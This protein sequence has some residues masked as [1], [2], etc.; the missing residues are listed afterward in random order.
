[1]KVMRYNGSYRYK[2][3]VRKRRMIIT[4]VLVTAAALIVAGG[5]L[6]HGIYAAQPVDD[7]IECILRNNESTEM[8]LAAG[9]SCLLTLPS[10]VDIHD[11]TFTSSDAETVRVDAA[12]R[13]DALREGGATVTA[14]AEG[15]SAEC[16]FAVEKAAK[17]E[18]SDEITTAYTA[19]GDIVAKNTKNGTDDLYN[20]VVNRRSNTVTVYTYDEN[21]EYT[22]PVRAMIASCGIGGKDITLT[23][24]FAVYFKDAWHQ[25]FGTV[26]GE[27]VYGMYIS[28]YDGNYLFHS[29]PYYTKDHGDL[30]ADEFNKLG[31]NASQGCVRLMA[32]D[33][34]WIYQN[35]PL[36]TPV[37]VIDADSSSDPLGTP[38]GV[39]IKSDVRWDP[40][41]PNPKN[42]FKGKIP[43]FGGVDDITIP[44]GESFS[45]SD[46]VTAQDICEN[47]I[48]D[49][50][51][52]TGEVITDKAGVYYIT[53]TVTDDFHLSATVTRAVT[54]A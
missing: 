46:G 45:I 19:N 9:E 41:D 1:M 35:C 25:L 26:E 27:V 44:S 24:D 49:R 17:A 32:S 11:V 51:H 38:P 42:P 2:S 4:L 53:Y 48:T 22:V 33:A 10:R 7:D 34:R 12:G 15:F 28:G 54:V 31:T 3:Q 21:K 23:G 8:A 30:E 14:V 5:F 52:I 29:V 40:T 43:S 16:V 36:N 47:D 18:K 50:I 13:A 37:R 20:I 6:V 39:K